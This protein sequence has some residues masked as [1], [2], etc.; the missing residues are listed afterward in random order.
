[1]SILTLPVSSMALLVLLGLSVWHDWRHRRIPNRLLALFA[2]LGLAHSLWPSGPGL[3]WALG[4]A[5]LGAG[6]FAPLYLRGGMGGG[7]IK[8]MATTGLWVGLAPMVLICLAVALSGGVLA[9]AWYWRLRRAAA[10]PLSPTSVCAPASAAGAVTDAPSPPLQAR[11][12]YA[13]AIAAGTLAVDLNR[14]W[15]DAPVLVPV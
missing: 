5:L 3:P 13:L 15:S 8:L 12:P 11:M 2:G 7:D 9:L 1:M 10:Q 14:L 4:G 6:A